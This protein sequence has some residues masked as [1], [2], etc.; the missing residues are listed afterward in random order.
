MNIL[1]GTLAFRLG[2]AYRRVDRLVNREL[3][4]LEISHADLHILFAVMERGELRVT[5]IAQLTGFEESTTSR[6]VRELA[7]RK[8]L[9]RRRN[10]TDARSHLLT[11]GT[12]TKNLR[13]E[14]EQITRRVQAQLV[15]DLP[16]VD[17]DGFLR[18]VDL[19]DRIP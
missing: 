7:R 19:L 11:V 16:Q 1:T 4:E 9:R 3:R 17:R 10:P 15:R 8:L 12:R 14:L 6:L 13:I 2:A 5:D 18:T